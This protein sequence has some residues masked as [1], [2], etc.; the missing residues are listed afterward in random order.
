MTSCNAPAILI[1]VAAA[2]RR[3]LALG[4]AGCLLPGLAEAQPGAARPIRLVVGF[5]PGGSADFIARLIAPAL[6]EALGTTVLVDNRPGASGTIAG[7]FVARS[8]PDGTTLLVGSASPVVISPQVLQ[9]S[10]F[11]PLTDLLGVNTI[12][13]TPQVIAVSPATG[14]RTL[15][16]LLAMARTQPVSLASSGTGGMTHLTIELLARAAGGKIVHVPYKGAGPS[17]TDALAGHVQG[18]VSDLTPLIPMLQDGRLQA[19]AVTSEK[20]IDLLPEVPAV[21][22]SLPGFSATNWAGVLAPAGTPRPLLLRLHAALGAVIGRED[23]RTQ[24]RKAG[25]VPASTES[26]EAFQKFIADDFARWGRLI[27]E[28]N[29][30]LTE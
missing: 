3:L 30:V 2:R 26:P 27:K 6:G 15:K 9:K 16:D 18:V 1:P 5:T 4:A 22:E 11:H 8:A 10:P 23:V 7:T 29:I 14:I 25:F 19:L 21:S 17:I 24:L 13:L 20:R 28:L 12:G